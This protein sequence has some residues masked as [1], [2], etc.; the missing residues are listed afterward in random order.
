MTSIKIKE[1]AIYHPENIVTN[2]FYIEEHKKQGNDVKEFLEDVLGRDKRY[3][4]DQDDENSF[5]M[6]LKASKHVLEKA[7][8]TGDVLDMIVF[9]SQTPEYLAT[10]N[11]IQLHHALKAGHHTMVMDS[12]ANCAGMMVAIDQTSRYLLQNE[13]VHT[14]LVVGSDFNTLMG[15]PEQA[16]T[17]GNLGDASCAII[18]EKTTED[19]GFIDSIYHT[20]SVTHANTFFPRHGL[21]KTIRGEA[22]DQSIDWIPFDGDMALAP[23]Y[24]MMEKILDRNHLSIKD[25]DA[26]CLSQFSIANIKR[27]Q[28]HFDIEDHKIMYIGDQFGYTGT[29]SPFIA[30]HEGIQ[31]GRIKRGDTVLFWT[32][33][34]GFQLAC[35]LFT[36]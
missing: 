16:I 28:S 4:I 26:F 11:A 7:S 10:T 36:Y 8:M 34:G 23:T 27:V 20:N 21:T 19:T 3:V 14:A 22:K 9:S 17:Y 31:T 30:L 32:I 18:L 15:N 12:N 35:M 24:E 5:T 29:S 25:I 1:I 13:H 6:A 33:G 2:E